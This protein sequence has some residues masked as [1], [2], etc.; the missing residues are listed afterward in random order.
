MLAH[1]LDL[2][3]VASPTTEQLSCHSVAA[4][5]LFAT[6]LAPVVSASHWLPAHFQEASCQN[7]ATRESGE[8][9][10]VGHG[11]LAVRRLGYGLP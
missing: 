1:L 4:V 5:A 7:L 3:L 2:S 9:T 11:P 6:A 10:V 8:L